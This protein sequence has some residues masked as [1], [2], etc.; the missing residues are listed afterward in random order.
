MKN[1]LSFTP[2]QR[3]GMGFT[4]VEILLALAILGIGLVSILSVFVVGTNSVRRTVAMTE[5]SF[6]AQ[7]VIAD[8]KSKGCDNI[9]S[10]TISK[11]YNADREAIYTDYICETD[12]QLVSGVGGVGDLKKVQLT[13]QHKNKDLLQFVTYIAKY[14]P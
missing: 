9:S 7:M 2:L 6:V 14:E 13:I 10:E 1:N 11:F 5:A 4:L 12:V 3:A 8:Y